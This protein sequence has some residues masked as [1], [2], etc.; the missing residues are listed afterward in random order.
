MICN[1]TCKFIYLHVPKTAGLAMAYVLVHEFEDCLENKIILGR[2]D[3]S[4]GGDALAGTCQQVAALRDTHC[5]FSEIEQ[6]LPCIRDLFSFAFVRNPWDRLFSL[7]HFLVHAAQDRVDGTRANQA[8][9]IPPEDDRQTVETLTRLGFHQWVMCVENDAPVLRQMQPQVTQASLLK[10]AD[11]KIGVNFVGAY[12]TLPE[13]WQAILDHR[14]MPPRGITGLPGGN[15]TRKPTP[16]WVGYDEATFNHVK[17]HHQEDIELFDYE[18][19]FSDLARMPYDL[20]KPTFSRE[21]RPIGIKEEA[22]GG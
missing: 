20:P 9:Q 10:N 4:P 16:W 6:E 22:P 12:E 5:S 7:Y 1:T 17:R 21:F 11:G 3:G 2:E 19:T 14:R 8:R 18:M 13:D 15:R